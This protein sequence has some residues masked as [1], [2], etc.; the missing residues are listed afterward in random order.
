MAKVKITV[1]LQN[2]FHM[3]EF[4]LLNSGLWWLE[5]LKCYI[6]VIFYVSI[7]GIHAAKNGLYF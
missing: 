1:H 3:K 6:M 4:I 2:I 7:H 5:G